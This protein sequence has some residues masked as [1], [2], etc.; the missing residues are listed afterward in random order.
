MIENE[1]VASAKVL[2]EQIHNKALFA[3]KTYKRSE[4]ELIEVLE[5]VDRHRVYYHQ[6]FNSLFK[7]A[8]DALSLSE[9]VAYIFINICRKVREVPALKEEIKSGN[10]TVSK[11]KR[12]TSVLAPQNQSYW[13]DLAKSASKKTLEKTVASVSPK[14]A[15]RE[16]LTYVHPELEIKER[17]SIVNLLEASEEA[18]RGLASPKEK[19]RVQLQVGISEKLM[20]SMR[21]VQDILSQ[22]QGK[23]VDL[24]ATLSAA[25]DLFIEKNDPLKKAERQVMRGKTLQDNG[26]KPQGP[27]TV[28]EV[29]ALRRQPIPRGTRHKLWLKFQGQCSHVG[30]NHQRC[31]ERRFLHVH[32]ERPVA[33]GGTNDLTNLSLLCAGHHR[34]EHLQK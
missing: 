29:P 18:K 30:D 31:H 6:G 28:S 12:I 10:I 1:N 7:Y 15:V 27:G 8:T 26:A 4:I 5:E 34:I 17:V 33:K 21:R 24:E 32:H 2:I 23:S 13:L 22:K 11:A 16:Q 3:A 20:L 25:I 19:A 14:A 9:E